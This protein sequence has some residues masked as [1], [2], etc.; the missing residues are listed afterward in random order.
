M[1]YYAKEHIEEW[2]AP[3]NEWCRNMLG[4]IT[5]YWFMRKV[6]IE[7]NSEKSEIIFSPYVLFH[8]CFAS[9]CEKTKLQIKDST[10]SW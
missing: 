4:R 6:K 5:V 7:V 1:S 8:V 9:D 2:K 10:F 3:E